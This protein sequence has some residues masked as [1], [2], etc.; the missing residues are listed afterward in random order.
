MPSACIFLRFDKFCVRHEGD[1]M[2]FIRFWWI[3]LDSTHRPAACYFLEF[4]ELHVRACGGPYDF[5]EMWV[6]FHG[7]YAY[8]CSLYFPEI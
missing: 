3:F 7:F 4:A 5:H 1:P 6:D 8:A 2:I